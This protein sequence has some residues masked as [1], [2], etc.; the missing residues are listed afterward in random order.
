MSASAKT[1][2]RSKLLNIVLLLILMLLVIFGYFYYK[3]TNVVTAIKQVVPAVS[4]VP[5]RPQYLFTIYGPPGEFFDRPNSVN[6][7]D[8][9]IYV[10]DGWNGRVVVFD[11]NGKFIRK[12][13]GRGNFQGAMKM[14]GEVAVYNNQMYVAD[15]QLGKVLVYTLDGNF[16]GYFAEKVFRSPLNIKVVNDKFYVFDTISQKFYILDSTGKVIKSFG[17]QGKEK[18]KFYFAWGFN[19]D[20]DG[21]IYIADSNNF[22]IQVFNPDGSFKAI[23]SGTKKDNSDGYTIPRGIAFD[24]KGNLWTANNLAG[25]VT[26]TSPAGKRLALFTNGESDEDT[27]TLPQSVFIDGNNRLYVPELGGNRVLV[28]QLQ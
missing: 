8:N 9:K 27:M 4:D 10:A 3:Q 16:I 19:L 21:N 23:W 11:Y 25:G 1:I 15:Y 26:A 22:R 20:K 6:V 14:P 28:Y 7:T 17:S 13:G 24:K 18:G 12:I 5:E 2:S